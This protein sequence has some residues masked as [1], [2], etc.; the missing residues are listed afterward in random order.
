MKS[1][2]R[3]FT[4]SVFLL[5]ILIAA[6]CARAAFSPLGVSIFPPLQFPPDDFTI[7]GFRLDL[8]MGKHRSVYGF[9]IGAVGNVTEQNLGGIQVAGAFN[10]NIGMTDAAGIQLAGITNINVNKANIVGLQVAGAVN[11]NQAESSIV[12]LQ[13]AALSNYSPYTKVYGMQVSLYNRARDVYGFQFGLLNVADSLHGVQI[14]LVNFNHTGLFA[15]API[16][17]I[18]F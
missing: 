2:L 8:L 4:K 10:Y 15:V 13:L 18:G 6:P 17:N 12:G 14:G 1:L 16:L 3:P 7:T 5:S 11:S 9:D